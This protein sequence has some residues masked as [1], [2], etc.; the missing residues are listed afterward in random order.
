MYY[1]IAFALPPIFLLVSAFGQ[2]PFFG[3]WFKELSTPWQITVASLTTLFSVLAQFWKPKDSFLPEIHP[4]LSKAGTK[5]L[6]NKLKTI[7]RKYKKNNWTFSVHVFSVENRFINMIEPVIA[8]TNFCLPRFFQFVFK[9]ELCLGEDLPQGFQMTINQGVSGLAYREGKST[10]ADDV[11]CF[12]I[13]APHEKI[14]RRFSKKQNLLT[15]DVIFIASCP[16]RPQRSRDGKIVYLNCGVLN[17][18]SRSKG[19]KAITEDATIQYTIQSL[20]ANFASEYG[21]LVFP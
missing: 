1:R 8:D 16:I 19:A 9:K 3:D 6:N 18:F 13:G 21:E 10:S 7:N 15:E 5:K 11:K 14:T 2:N 20:A 17:L 4:Q 12:S